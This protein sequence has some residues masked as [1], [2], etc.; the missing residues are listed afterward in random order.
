MVADT[1]LV[2]G[3]IELN[4]PVAT[5]LAFV[6]PAGWVSVF[7]AP[8]AARTT[9]A[10][11]IGYPF[12]SLAVTVI[13]DEP[14]PSPVAAG[15]G[16]AVAVEAATHPTPTDTAAAALMPAPLMVADAVVVAA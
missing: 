8:V 14:L 3:T 15:D 13:V 7:P 6:V 12:A 1:V 4:V 10:P 2:P 9:V 16:P 5:P 11:G